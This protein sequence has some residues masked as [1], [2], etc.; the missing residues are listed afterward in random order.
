MSEALL[1]A[2]VHATEDLEKV[3]QAVLNLLP[4][5]LRDR[6]RASCEEVRGHY[7]NPIR[8]LRLR[9][10]GSEVEALLRFL[11]DNM[12]EPDKLSIR[13]TLGLRVDEEGHL[14]M[15]FD[16]ASAFRGEVRLTNR[17]EAVKVRVLLPLSRLEFLRELLAE[18][19]LIK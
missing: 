15:R 10:R 14:Y 4:P 9:L 7:N 8:I 17:G 19:G 5:E 3:A 6:D 1:E 18:V 16:K 13:E 11:A 2:L 12:S